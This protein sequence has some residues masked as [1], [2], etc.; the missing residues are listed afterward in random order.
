MLALLVGS[1]YTT[2]V[3]GV[4]PVTAMEILAS[5][6]F[7]KRQLLSEESKQARYAQMVKGLQEFKQWVRAGK[8]TDNTSL[9][10]KLKNVALNEEFPSVRVSNFLLVLLFLLGNIL[11]LIL[12][13]IFL[14]WF[15]LTWNLT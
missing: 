10:K 8:R 2:G 6:P 3:S 11:L 4:G 1:D 12:C 5:F 7:N 13:I 14:R 9:K 15:R